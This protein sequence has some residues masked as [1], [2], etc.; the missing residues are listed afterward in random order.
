[1]ARELTLIAQFTVP[2]NAPANSTVTVD[3]IV[4][5]RLGSQSV[6]IVPT[7]YDIII[8][9]IYVT[10][11]PAVDAVVNIVKNQEE[12]VAT[13]DPLS[14]MNV[15][16]VARPRVKPLVFRSGE[17]LSA[18]AVTLA[19]GGASDQTITFYIKAELIERGTAKAPRGLLAKLAGF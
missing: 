6:Y 5:P 13:T 10:N 17:M 16:N 14:T 15:N 1:M 4:D 19:V 2:A 8:K 7:G 18:Q 9:D 3:F 11:T 12:V